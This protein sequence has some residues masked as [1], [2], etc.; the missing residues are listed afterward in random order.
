MSSLL[1]PLAAALAG[2]GPLAAWTV[3]AVT[4]P[5]GQAIEE[6][7]GDDRWGCEILLCMSNP[8]GPKAVAECVPPIDRLYREMHKK[9]FKWPHCPQAGAGNYV[10]PV[11]DPYDPCGAAGL[12]DAPVGW[13]AEGRDRNRLT[14]ARRYNAAGAYDAETGSWGAKA[15]VQ[16]PAVG[17]YYT[18]HCTGSWPDEECRRIPV[19]LYSR[20]EWM[21]Q[22]APTAFD[23]YIDGKLFHRVHQ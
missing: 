7:R 20:V 1:K 13:I 8:A 9:H 6:L 23:V 4:L 22:K 16:A 12:A 5:N 21:P 19:T 3:G 15:C 18:T 17:R 10:R 11:R 2:F 14:Q